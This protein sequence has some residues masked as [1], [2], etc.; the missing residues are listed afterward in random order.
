MFDQTRQGGSGHEQTLFAFAQTEL[1]LRNAEQLV[2]D[3]AHA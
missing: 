2:K 1:W 3:S